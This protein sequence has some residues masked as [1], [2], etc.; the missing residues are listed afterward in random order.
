MATVKP[1]KIRFQWNGGQKIA[2][3]PPATTFNALLTF[4][5]EASGVPKAA[6]KRMNLA[7]QMLV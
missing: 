2:P 5:E 6:M 4:A 3:L 1:I 7:F